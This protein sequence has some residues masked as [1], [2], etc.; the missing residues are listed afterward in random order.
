MIA[1]TSDKL[2]EQVLET[3]D[4]LLKA[5][6][7][8]CLEEE[9]RTL[10]AEAWRWMVGRHPY[11]NR[12]KHYVWGRLDTRHRFSFDRS[13]LGESFLP[14]NVFKELEEDKLGDKWP[15]SPYQIYSYLRVALQAA[16]SAYVESKSK[17]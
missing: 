9:G 16:V 4:D 6:L 10:E 13:E 17:G 3:D 7:A 14:L 8:D 2:L 1:T 12:A 11:Q 15:T 5:V